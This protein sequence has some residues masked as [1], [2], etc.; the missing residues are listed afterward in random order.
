VPRFASKRA[1]FKAKPPARRP[2]TPRR[3]APRRQK[4]PCPQQ[5]LAT[6]EPPAAH[7][8]GGR[9]QPP[10]TQ[11]QPVPSQRAP[12]PGPPHGPSLRRASA[13]CP[14]IRVVAYQPA[15]PRAGRGTRARPQ[16]GIFA[17]QP[18]SPGTG[19][20]RC[21]SPQIRI[22]AGTD[23]A[24]RS[25]SQPL[26][27]SRRSAYLRSSAP[28]ILFPS[29][30]TR[31]A[32]SI[33]RAHPQPPRG[34]RPRPSAPTAKRAQQRHTTRAQ[35][36]RRAGAMLSLQPRTL[37]RATALAPH[38]LPAPS[39]SAQTGLPQPHAPVRR[40]PPTP[41][42][43]CL[44]KPACQNPL[45]LYAACR[46]PQVSPKEHRSQRA[47][48]QRHTPREPSS[49]RLRSAASGGPSALGGRR[50]PSACPT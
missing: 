32:S 5:R 2:P 4:Q 21:A 19:D 22:A 34:R 14:Q 15:S 6:R 28:K 13:G 8:R 25:V 31:R 37:Q 27:N 43:P 3:V 20:D 30:P 33:T 7:L 40:L 9:R 36:D 10:P 12:R 26:Q 35:A 42:H 47:P 50:H 17:Y 1:P 41:Q 16:N 29:A 24:I 48:Q 23:C 39:L 38:P 45:H 11:R 18:S 46:G 49:T 44:R